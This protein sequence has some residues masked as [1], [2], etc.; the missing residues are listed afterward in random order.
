[1]KTKNKKVSKLPSYLLYRRILKEGQRLVALD[2]ENFL[3]ILMN[4]AWKLTTLIIHRN[5]KVTSKLKVFYQFGKYL[6]F[7]NKKHGSIFVAKYLKAALLA[8]QRRIA[9]SPVKSLREIEPDLPLPRLSSSGL[10][11]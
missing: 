3:D 8:I 6:V 11:A 10:P 2:S 5:V 4:Y 1:M 7:L 9:G